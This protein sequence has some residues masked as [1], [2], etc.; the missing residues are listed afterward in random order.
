MINLLKISLLERVGEPIEGKA[1]FIAKASATLKFK[2]LFE[3]TPNVEEDLLL[4]NVSDIILNDL[5]EKSKDYFNA[6]GVWITAEDKV[7]E[8]SIDLTA[9]ENM[10]EYGGEE[11]VPIFEFIKMTITPD[12][13]G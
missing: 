5:T 7:Y 4:Q 12:A 2:E 9:F 1:D 3:K 11:V 13:V 8:N 6:I 10:K